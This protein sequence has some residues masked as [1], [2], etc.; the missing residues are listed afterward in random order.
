MIT[1]ESPDLKRLAAGATLYPKAQRSALRKELAAAAL[2]AAKASRSKIRGMPVKGDI[3][4]KEA[5][6][7]R[8]AI[9][10]ATKAVTTVNSLGAGSKIYVAKSGALAAHNRWRVAQLFDGGAQ[11][12]AYSAGGGGSFI[13]PV[14]GTKTLV[15]Q[16]GFPYFKTVIAERAPAIREAMQR[17]LLAAAKATLPNVH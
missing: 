13:H 4:Y 6:D 5:A 11:F 12:G 2:E 3:P 15:S 17:T 16:G 1:V 10:A 9:G 8:A 14:Y 7:L